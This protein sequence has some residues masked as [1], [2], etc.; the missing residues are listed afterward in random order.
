MT[1]NS[2]NLSIVT[3]DHLYENKH[4]DDAWEYFKD[5]L[6]VR[7]R[8]FGPD[9]HQYMLPYDMSDFF[10]RHHLF[11]IKEGN[12]SKCIGCVKHVSLRL[13]NSYHTPFPIDKLTH[14]TNSKPHIEA[15]SEI[16]GSSQPNSKDILYGGGF[17]IEKSFR[18]KEGNS[19]LI[20][21]L[22]AALSCLDLVQLHAGSIIGLASIRFKTDR[23]FESIGYE[24]IMNNNRP[25]DPI[26]LDYLNG[27][28]VTWIQLKTPSLWSRQC[29][30]QHQTLIS[31]RKVV[32]APERTKKAA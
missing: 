9:H 10:A 27:D 20:K 22:V 6:K 23:Y 24:R 12:R 18:N 13:C 16:L 1:G 3:L 30:E 25:L 31:K 4:N 32:S 7:A 17:A 21:E 19:K 14:S 15:I 2:S 5:M 28:E 26:A 8:G 11:Y 29:L